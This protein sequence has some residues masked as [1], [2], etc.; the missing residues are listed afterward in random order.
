VRRWLLEIKLASKREKD[1]REKAVAI[2]DKYRGKDRKKNS[3]NI[4]WANTE[5]LRPALY[6]STPKPDVRRR[7][8]QNDMLGKAV[9]EVAERSLSYCIDAYDLDNC[10]KNDVLDA[11]LPG[12]GLSRVRYIP[13]FKDAQPA[14]A[15]RAE[16]GQTNEA[17]P[18]PQAQSRIN[19][20]IYQ[21]KQKSTAPRQAGRRRIDRRG[22]GI[23]AGP[24]RA[25]PMGR[26]PP[27]AG[28]DVG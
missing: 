27:G 26:L 2:L 17:Q 25:R 10:V 8:R 22:A 12:R 9:A 3:F 21:G 13:Q 19:H 1:W 16:E 18:A 7:F 15:C 11:L 5:V 24:V 4:L 14:A 28:Q 23:S 20:G 6:N